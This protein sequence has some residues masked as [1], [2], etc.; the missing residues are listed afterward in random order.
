MASNIALQL[1]NEQSKEDL[2]YLQRKYLIESFLQFAR[3]EERSPFQR[4]DDISRILVCTKSFEDR[5]V[6]VI[7]EVTAMRDEIARSLG[8]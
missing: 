3:D 2:G 1:E 6:G 8:V 4:L 5:F 7:A